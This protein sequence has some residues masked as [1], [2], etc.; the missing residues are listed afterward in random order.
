MPRYSFT[1]IHGGRPSGPGIVAECRDNDAAKR[2]A[3]GVFADV[4]RDI[5]KDLQSM[6]DWQI[7]VA[8]AAGSAFFRI[9]ITVDT[10][11]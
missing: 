3:A 11:E 7:E 4:A 2:E 1:N 5:A 10:W 8:D 6:P 9:K